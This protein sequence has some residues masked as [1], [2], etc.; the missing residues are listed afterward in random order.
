MD[1]ED[2]VAPDAVVLARYMDELLNHT[3]HDTGYRALIT[4]RVRDRLARVRDQDNRSS[5]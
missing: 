4:E 3:D 2:A 1:D 5:S